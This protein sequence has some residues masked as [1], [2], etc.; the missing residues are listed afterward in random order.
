MIV[1]I[2]IIIRMRIIMIVVPTEGGTNVLEVVRSSFATGKRCARVR[3]ARLLFLLRAAAGEVVCSWLVQASWPIIIPASFFRPGRD[4]AFT[5]RNATG[6]VERGHDAH[7]PKLWRSM[8]RTRFK[9]FVVVVVEID[10]T[11]VEQCCFALC[12]TVQERAA[13]IGRRSCPE[14]GAL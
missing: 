11:N 3:C 4:V 14:T 10:I 8:E 12:D 7:R 1:R 2:N 6:R 9:C 5:V 13:T